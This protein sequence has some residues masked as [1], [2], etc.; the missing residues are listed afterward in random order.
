MVQAWSPATTAQLE[1]LVARYAAMDSAL[2]ATHFTRL[3][4]NRARGPPLRVGRDRRC[5]QARPAGQR[6]DP[7]L[8]VRGHRRGQHPRRGGGPAG[9]DLL[10]R[11]RLPPRTPQ[12]RHLQR[13][14]RGADRRRR[15]G[16]L[17]RRAGRVL[18]ARVR[19]Q[20]RAATRAVWFKDEQGKGGYYD[21]DGKSKRRSFLASPLEFS[22]V[23]SGFAMRMHP[24]LNQWRQHKGVDY[25]APR[26]TPVRAVGDGRRRVRRLAERLRQRH[27]DPATA[28][29]AATLYAHLSRIDVKAGQRVEQGEHIGAVGSTGWATGPHLHFEFKVAGVQQDPVRDG[30]GV[31]GNASWHPAAQGTLRCA[32]S[33]QT[34]RSQLEAAEH[35]SAAPAPTSSSVRRIPV[36]SGAPAPPIAA[37]WPERLHRP[38]VGHVAR[39]H[40]W[41]AGRLRGRPRRC[42]VLAPRAPAV[43]RRRSPTNCSRSTPSGANELHRAALAGNRAGPGLRRRSSTRCSKRRGA[44]PATCA[45]IGAHGQTVRHRPRRIRRHRLHAA[46]QQRRRCWPNSPASMSSPTSAV[47]TSPRAAKARRWCRR[48]TARCSRRTDR[49]VARAEPRRHHQPDACLR[50][51]GADA[52]ASTAARATR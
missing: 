44:G 47:A 34:V 14:L 42:T 17:G 7:L 12:G 50:A 21:L 30:P 32:A 35:R 27:R 13:G 6:H 25:G 24:I 11:H 38:D 2:A 3:K 19:Q 51:D 28:T 37:R 8:P 20:G 4:V 40:R 26:G 16:H 41:R 23:T 22:R 18:A 31:G 48:S 15:A 39:R 36:A 1:E 45:A 49:T 33:A 29:T 5:W 43:R 52:S 9:R 10:H 46:D